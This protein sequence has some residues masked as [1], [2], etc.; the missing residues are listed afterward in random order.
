MRIVVPGGAGKMGCIAVQDLAG[1]RRVDEVVVADRDKTQVRT[2][3]ETIGSSKVT[4]QQVDLNDRD[5]LIGTLKGANTC[6]NTTV[7]SLI[8]RA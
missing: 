6:L 3:A 4:I 7:A 8:G 5:V 2:V 1:D